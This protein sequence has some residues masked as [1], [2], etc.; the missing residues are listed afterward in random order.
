MMSQTHPMAVLPLAHKELA[1]T[2]EKVQQGWS[3]EA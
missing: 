2:L 3:L 1:D